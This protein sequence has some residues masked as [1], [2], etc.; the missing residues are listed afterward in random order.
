MSVRVRALSAKYS[1]DVQG[2]MKLV[3]E[4]GSQIAK[5]DVA[6]MERLQFLHG[7]IEP[8]FGEAEVA[9][10]QERMG[11]AWRKVIAKIDELSG[12][13]KEAIEATEQRFPAGG[14]QPEDEPAADGVAAG[15]G[16]SPVPVRAS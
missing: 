8:E 15:N 13:D 16:G 12:I 6:A 4:G 1:A 14:D 5:I 7:V 2:Q 3:Q 10:I 9:I 11:S